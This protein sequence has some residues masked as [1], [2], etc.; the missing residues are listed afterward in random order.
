VGSVA[1]VVRG[2]GSTTSD[3]RAAAPA[4]TFAALRAATSPFIGP[5]TAGVITAGV[6]GVAVLPESGV[7]GTTAGDVMAVGV[8]VS[9]ADVSGEVGGV[10]VNRGELGGVVS[11]PGGGVSSD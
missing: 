1:A 5:A 8:P 7:S 9:A 10:C 11:S 2:E 4:A 6:I 3:V